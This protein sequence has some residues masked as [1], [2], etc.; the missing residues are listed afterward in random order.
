VK[1][2]YSPTSP[3]VRKV[4]ICAIELGLDGRIERLPAAAHPVD[5]DRTIVA[6][7]PLGQVPT[8]FTDDGT[9]LYDSRVVCEYLDGLAGGRF[10]PTL[11]PARWRALT[12]QSLADGLLDAALL[13]RYERIARPPE[14]Q[15]KAWEDGQIDKIRCALDTLETWVP[16]FAGRLDIGTITAGCALGYLDFRFSDLAWRQGRP[17]LAGWFAE[18]SERPSFAATVPV[19]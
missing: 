14:R 1:L 5:R 15:W 17:A 4:M 13:T 18:I 6:N 19:G 11:G 8:F 7:N 3:F 16:G 10:F 9:V 12:E 2:H